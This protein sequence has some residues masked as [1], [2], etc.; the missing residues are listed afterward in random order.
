M[1]KVYFTRKNLIELSLVFFFF[2]FFLFV[3]ACV[4]AG[5]IFFA[6]NNPIEILYL[7]IGLPSVKAGTVGYVTAILVFVYMT[8]CDAGLIFVRRL[9]KFSKQSVFTLKWISLSILII[10]LTVALSFGLG[11]YYVSRVNESIMPVLQMV[12]GSLLISFI[13]YLFLGSIVF[14]VAALFVNF[15]NIDKP[16]RFFNVSEEEQYEKELDAQVEQEQDDQDNLALKFGDVQPTTAQDSLAGG[17]G[18]SGGTSV[19][20]KM[21]IEG[22]EKVFPGL[23]TIDLEHEGFI[24][25]RIK[26][27]GITL[28]GFCHDFRNYL[29]HKQELYFDIKTIRAFVS[30]LA[31]SKMIILQGLSGTGK[32]SLPRYFAKF[33]GSRPNF[34]PVQTTWRDKT[35]II[36]YF[37]DFT[38]T[39][40]ETEF[41]KQMYRATYEVDRLNIM[42]LDEFNIARIEYYFAEF[43]SVLEFPENEQFIKVMQLP[44]DFIPP[45][46]LSAGMLKIEPNTYFICTANKDDSTFSISDKVYDRSIVIDFD[47]RNEPFTV[48]S[49]VKELKLGYEELSDLFKSARKDKKNTLSNE[50]LKQFR[51]I[52][53]YVHEKFDITFGNRIMNQIAQFVPVYIACGGTKEEALD[54]MFARKVLTKIQGRYEDHI[55]AGL[56]TLSKM[57][58]KQYGTGVFKE[59]KHLIAVQVKQL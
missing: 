58:D 48:K 7:G 55:K 43:L 47:D 40:N 13:L 16:Y 54:F 30:G 39:F 21:I 50:D 38:Q 27:V 20:G 33:I 34:N 57:L 3:F 10:L 53:D 6:E 18:G 29:A 5:H 32:S 19:A 24:T 36:G 35:S 26:P 45:T 1:K 42:V 23:S 37:N 12:G 31:T 4:D 44:Y 59:S 11:L 15:R 17:S 52:T 9:A 49:D 25:P 8:V 2:L 22:R 51:V 41:L 46:H 14:C 28:E 56:L